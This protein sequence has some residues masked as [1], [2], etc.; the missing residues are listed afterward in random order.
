MTERFYFDVWPASDLNGTALGE[1]TEAFDRHVRVAD[2]A[3]GNGQFSINRH[4]SQAAWCVPDNL[5]RVR[6]EAGGP[7]DYDDDRYFYAFM[8][9]EGSDVVVS[10]EEAG[11]ETITRGGRDA[12]PVM[13]SRARIYPFSTHPDNG[14]YWRRALKDGVVRINET[15][16]GLQRHPGTAFRI[17]FR[18]AEAR[19]PNPLAPMNDTFNFDHDSNGT[20]WTEQGP[21]DWE[22]AVGITLLEL[23]SLLVAQGL[24]TRWD[25]KLLL[26][27]YDTTQGDDLSGSITFGKG[28]NIRTSAE[29]TI[30]AS[31]AV[32]RTIVKGTTADGTLKYREVVHPTLPAQIGRREGYTEYEATPTNAILDRAG[33]KYMN[34]LANQHEGPVSIGAKD[35]P[36]RTAFADYFPGDTVGVDVPGE[37][38]EEPAR[39]IAINLDEEANG[40]YHPTLEFT[41]S[42]W[43]GSEGTDATSPGLGTDPPGGGN[44]NCRDCPPLEPY[45]PPPDEVVCN[46]DP[47]IVP[48]AGAQNDTTQ[49]SAFV[50]APL[51]VDGNIA[52]TASRNSGAGGGNQHCAIIFDMGSTVFLE[53]FDVWGNVAGLSIFEGGDPDTVVQVGPSAGGPWTAL[54]GTFNTATS[55]ESFTR[56]GSAVAGRYLRLYFEDPNAG[57]HFW[58]WIQVHEIGN[59]MACVGDVIT[60][61]P[62]VG[63]RAQEELPGDSAGDTLTTNYPYQEGSLVVTV[64]GV[65]VVATQTD[66]AAGEFT[67]PI[68]TTGKTVRVSYTVASTT[69]TGATNDPWSPA[70]D[71]HVSDS[72]GAHAA[73]AVSFSPT[74]TIAATN[75]QAAI[76]EV[77]S[78]NDLAGHTGDTTDAHDASAI[79]IADA[80]AYYSG[81]DVEA[82]L[83]EIGA[84][85]IGGGGGG[86]D[87]VGIAGVVTP[88]AVA[89]IDSQNVTGNFNGS[90]PILGNTWGTA[91]F[92]RFVI[93]DIPTAPYVGL[94]VVLAELHLYRIDTN[95]AGATDRVL[96]ARRILRQ[97][98]V[99]SEVTW[100]VYKSGSNWTTAGARSVG[101]DIDTERTKGDQIGA[102]ADA[103]QWHRVDVTKLLRDA[104]AAGDSRLLVIVSSSV[105]GFGSNLVRFEDVAD[106]NGPKLHVL[107]NVS[108]GL[109]SQGVGAKLYKSGTQAVTIGTPVILS[110]TDA[111]KDTGGYW[112]AGAPTRLTVPPGMGGWHF[113][114]GFVYHSGNAGA[115]LV[116]FKKGG[117]SYL[118]GGNV[119]TASAGT[120]SV[121]L[122][123]LE[124]GEY[125]ELELVPGSTSNI[126]HASAVEAFP[127]FEIA[128]LGMGAPASKQIR[129]A[130]ATLSV[131][132]ATWTAVTPSDAEETFDDG[133]WHSGTS[134]TFTVP[135]GIT[136]VRAAG[137]WRTPGVTAGHRYIRFIKNGTQI[138]S[139]F[140]MAGSVAGGNGAQINFSD[141]FVV[142]PGDTVGMEVYQ[143]SG[144]TVANAGAEV[145]FEGKAA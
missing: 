89:Y 107:T 132:N 6:R 103:D 133:G 81:S 74:G 139:S 85:G 114:R 88:T 124:A 127:V 73:S 109:S 97:D 92:T 28:D 101:N 90:Q 134:S 66:P 47:E 120:E 108:N 93:V 50:D 135:A 78:E 100:N 21:G 112:S 70:S 116:R 60:G 46:G 38:E 143:D 102:A 32:S 1:L 142:A 42:Q 2:N 11:G 56:T 55:P 33:Q 35:K 131:T 40:T 59:L 94:D 69:G 51:A 96:E 105:D 39:I 110:W 65:A 72:S 111:L 145:S 3:I 12:V 49:P 144:G 37:Y 129:C 99:M 125:L 53:S 19:T 76:A 71:D 63:Q 61:S 26:Y 57:L 43:D 20:N 122:A 130:D 128:R 16:G 17:C 118:H 68:D 62:V 84:G 117:T 115:E 31:P 104:L 23:L 80:G 18:D 138:G 41:E 14:V 86:G 67:L 44:G 36:G 136:R 5:V 54:T 113:L 123:Y 140:S 30:H 87:G 22:F 24:Y 95:N 29:R 121:M 141:W 10:T 27:A 83:Q 13:L 25:A 4:S 75:V 7:F 48:F 106:A 77:A 58:P 98:L 45:V 137:V 126:G 8:I 52:T 15:S 91:A 79:S 64:E 9:E 82:A 119:Y 34:K